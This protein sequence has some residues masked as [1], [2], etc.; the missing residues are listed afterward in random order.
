MV[1]LGKRT[2]G[3]VRRQLVLWEHKMR[4]LYRIAS[5]VS[6][7]MLFVTVALHGV[8]F[9]IDP[10]VNFIKIGP[11]NYVTLVARG[12]DCRLAFFNDPNAGP[13]QGS[14]VSISGGSEVTTTAFGD[15]FGIYYRRF[16]WTD[17]SLFTLSVSLLY[18]IAGFA[19]LPICYFGRRLSATV[20]Q[21]P[22]NKGLQT[23]A[24]IGRFDLRRVS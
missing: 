11:S 20:R 17:R 3:K 5:T 22:Q 23:K 1:N 6:T 14:I 24:A 12:F 16:E 2:F 13:Y 19:I 8:A 15:S 9:K 21:K 4:T 18:A 10:R 7:L